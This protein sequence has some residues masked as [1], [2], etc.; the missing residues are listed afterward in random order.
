MHKPAADHENAVAVIGMAGRFP[1]SPNLHEFWANLSSGIES[2]TRFSD[3]E[4][5]AAGVSP[6]LLASADYVKAAPVLGDIS[7]FDAK[8]FDFSPKEAAVTDPQHRLFLQCA[9]EALES[10]GY[11]GEGYP[12]AI[13]VFAGSGPSMGSYLASEH[14]V[15]QKLF[16]SSASREHIGND[17]DYLATRV[18]YKLNLRGPSINVQTACSTSLVSVHLACQSL[19]F[20]ESDIALAGGVTVRLPQVSGY[21]SRSNAILSPTGYCRAFDSRAD[22]TLFGSGVGVIA[23]K[24]LDRAIADRDVIHA[25]IRGSA[26][27]NDGAQKTSFWSSSAEGQLRSMVEALAIADVQPQY[28]GFVEAHGTATMIGDPVEVMALTR[29]FRSGTDRRGFCALGSVKTNVGHLDSASGIAGLLKAILALKH[30]VIPPTLHFET[31]NPRIRFDKTPFFVNTQ[32]RNWPTD[33]VPRLAAVN[34]LGIGGT[35]AFVV[36]EQAPDLSPA[37]PSDRTSHLLTL[38]AKTEPALRELASRYQQQLDRNPNQR[39][40]DICHTVAV[41]RPRLPHR[42]ACAV[43]SRDSARQALAG[44]AAG[45]AVRSGHRGAVASGTRPKLAFLFDGSRVARIDTYAR[46]CAIK[47]SFQNALVQCRNAIAEATG[48]DPLKPLDDG[49]RDEAVE[50]TLAGFAIDFAMATMWRQW[51]IEPA[52][53]CGQGLGELTAACV[54]KALSLPDAARL[55]NAAPNDRSELAQSMIL[56]KGEIDLVSAVSGEITQESSTAAD[57]IGFAEGDPGREEA[58]ASAFKESGVDIL[59]QIGGCPEAWAELG[60]HLDEEQMFLTGSHGS[61]DLWTKLHAALAQMFVRGVSI[62]F[63]EVDR[64]FGLSRVELPSYPFQTK[65]FWIEP[66]NTMLAND[67]TSEY[68]RAA[69]HPLLGRRIYSALDPEAIL[70]EATWDTQEPPATT[71][72][73]SLLSNEETLRQ[74]VLA[75]ATSAANLNK[76]QLKAFDLVTPVR[77]L[78]AEQIVV[79][80]AVKQERDSCAVEVFAR[81]AGN[82]QTDISWKTIAK[83]KALWRQ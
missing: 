59:L 60:P 69:G 29:A 15:N 42:F 45:D 56:H 51:G 54:A 32:C 79:Q 81:P 19:L 68:D 65:R 62:K 16:R 53:V 20:G 31:P 1:G 14:H 17:K 75:A 28:I 55:V 72:P 73:I 44:L 9:Y 27:N 33:N 10:A 78:R 4:L 25:V 74:L 5:I 38:S 63:E 58:L 76:P 24:T 61:V 34:S 21:S 70:F 43:Q 52:V 18:S 47:P 39:L 13:G 11:A 82:D 48:D 50:S 67:L 64:G 49:P 3:E 46:L 57:L 35:N 40:A 12:G 22:G 30:A 26:I 77:E 80:T 2:I 41:G 83:G 23:L 7:L 37:A 71:R 6:Q 36:L 8:F 66:T